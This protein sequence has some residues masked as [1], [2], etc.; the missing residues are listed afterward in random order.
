MACS[1]HNHHVEI[2]TFRVKRSHKKSRLGCVTCKRRRVKVRPLYSCSGTPAPKRE[3]S[4]DEYMCL[5]SAT[6]R[7]PAVRGAGTVGWNAPTRSGP[8][9]RPQVRLLRQAGQS[10]PSLARSRSPLLMARR[11]RTRS[12]GKT[13]VPLLFPTSS[14]RSTTMRTPSRLS[15]RQGYVIRSPAS[16]MS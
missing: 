14:L 5:S 7:D 4:A 8:S 16:G 9:Q 15:R 11:P 12:L 13:T 3:R 6:R 1:T 10:D 2:P